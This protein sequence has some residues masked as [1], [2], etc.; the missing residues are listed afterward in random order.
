MTTTEKAILLIHRS[1][2]TQSEF[3]ENLNMSLRSLQYR[4]SGKRE[5]TDMEAKYIEDRWINSNSL[6]R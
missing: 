3:A 5:W 4:M 6:Y 1:Q 2:C